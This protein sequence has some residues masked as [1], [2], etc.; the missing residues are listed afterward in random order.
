[1]PPDAPSEPLPFWLVNVPRDE[2]P[3]KCPDFL[4]GLST[5]DERI[6]GTPD[7]EYH[8]MTWPEVQKAVEANRPDLFQRV[9]SDLRKYRKYTFMLTKQYGSIMNF[10]LKQRLQWLDLTPNGG[11][12]VYPEDIKILH[13]DWPY[14]VDEKIV[15][16]VIWTKFDLEDDPAT[17]DLTPEAREQIDEYVNKT[18]CT[19]V[20][21]DRVIWFKNWRSLKSVHAVEHFHVMLYDPDPAFIEEITNG[22][23]PLSAKVP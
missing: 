17:D 2:W 7:S 11:P 3:A 15:H 13:N 14:G 16:L 9:P 20:N 4:S 6:I 10:V 12:F 19:R 5:K 1:M 18:F 8:R 21:P 22:D 23:V